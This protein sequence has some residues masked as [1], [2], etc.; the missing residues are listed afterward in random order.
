MEEN[1]KEKHREYLKNHEG[2]RYL[3]AQGESAVKKKWKLNYKDKDYNEN[4]NLN[5]PN[6][7]ELI[8]EFDETPN[9]Y[10]K[11]EKQKSTKEQRLRWIKKTQKKLNKDKITYD[12]FDHKGKCPH[13]HIILSRDSTKEE[14][15][16]I[17]KFYVPEKAFKYAD[18]SLC[19]K[20][21]I[22]T[23]YA[24]HWKYGTYKLLVKRYNDK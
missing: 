1:L 18:L 19:G 6:N 12:L 10:F 7:D 14:K 8:I 15:E 5:E 9:H 4:I 22:A 24:K 23:P 17:V 11:D 2:C 16:S 13:I 21:L 20:H 3:E